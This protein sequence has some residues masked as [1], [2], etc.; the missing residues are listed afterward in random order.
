VVRAEARLRRAGHR[1]DGDCWLTISACDTSFER[2]HLGLLTWYWAIAECC[3]KAERV[4][5]GAG[6]PTYKERLCAR[7]VPAAAFAVFRSP[8]APYL[9]RS[10]VAARLRTTVWSTAAG[11]WVLPR[12]GEARRRLRSRLRRSLAGTP[13]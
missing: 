2:F 12:L 3:G 7:G 13:R 6:T 1:E 4:H 11:R 9:I 8:F 5:L 10:E